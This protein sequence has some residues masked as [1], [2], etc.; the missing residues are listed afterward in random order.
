MTSVWALVVAAGAG[1]R[2]T[3]DGRALIKQ[4]QPL[5]G[6]TVLATSVAALL[7][8]AAVRGV[9]VVLAEQDPVRLADDPRIFYCAGGAERHLSVRL[10]LQ[11]LAS[12]ALPSDLI[13]VHDAARPCVR[14]SDIQQLITRWQ[15]LAVQG[16]DRVALCL[17]SP[18]VDTLHKVDESF[19]VLATPDR[20]SLWRA[21]TPQAANL[22]TLL[23][24]LQADLAH[25]VKDEAEA[26]M[27]LG[28]RV[29]MVAGAADN[30]KITFPA[31]LAMAEHI[32]R[33]NSNGTPFKIGQGY[34][35]HAFKPGDHIVLGGVTIP[36]DHAIAAH[37][38]GDVLLHAI[39]DAVLGALGLG[40]IGVH[41]PDTDAAFKGISSRQLLACVITQM[42]DQGWQLSNLDATVIA[43][44]PKLRPHVAAM[45]ICLAE[46]FSVGVEAINI[47]ATTT[48]RLGF[49]GREEG[50]A[51][52]A[53][54]LLTRI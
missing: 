5:C 19:H 28:G 26:V 30:I 32:I 14:P 50:L 49:I 27:R 3:T 13:L 11:A 2:Y 34:D 43:Q 53:V 40:D 42:R 33:Q 45:Q 46:D 1:N 15:A 51:A 7:Q 9:M 23:S 22:R 39:C 38:D 48:E 25:P 6:K 35:V 36:H 47:K 12:L 52:E 18:C 24:A 31:D 17:G 41:F 16:Q 54:V 44:R 4:H 29:M 10:G 8:V 21:F 20:Q 37:S